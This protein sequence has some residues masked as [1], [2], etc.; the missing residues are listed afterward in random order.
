MSE[1][2]DRIAE[3]IEKSQFL[4]FATENVSKNN[5]STQA[6]EIQQEKRTRDIFGRLQIL[7][8]TKQIDVKIIFAYPEPPCFCHPDDCF[9]RDSP[10]SKVFRYWKNLVQSNNPPNI[11]TMIADG[12]FLIRS[13]R[14]CLTYSCF[15]RKVLKVNLKKPIHHADICFDVYESSSIK[16]SIRQELGNDT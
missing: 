8:V 16:Q 2:S 10:K 14:H 9:L 13:T 15:V 4:N 1:K 3:A 11:E 7:A 6:S 5:I 12:M